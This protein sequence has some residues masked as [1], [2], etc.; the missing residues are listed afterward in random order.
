MARTPLLRR[1]SET[2]WRPA[3]A[4]SADG[5]ADGRVLARR[6]PQAC[7]R[8]RRR[9]SPLGSGRAA[10]R[11]QAATAPRIAIVG[12]GIAG[13]NAA[14]TLAGQGRTARRSTRR[15]RPNRRPHALR[16]VGLLGERAGVR[17]LRRAD[18]HGSQEDPQPREHA[19]TC[20]LVDLLAA[21]PSGTEDTYWF[22]GGDYPARPGR[23]R[24]SARSH[25]TL[26][27][28]GQGGRLSD[29]CTTAPRRRAAVR[30]DVGLR[31]DRGLRS[32]RPRL[33]IGRAARRRVQR[34]VRRRDEGPGVA[35]P[36][37]SARLPADADGFEVFG[38]SDERFHIAGGNQQ[39]P[40]AIAN[41]LG[42]QT[43]KLGLGDAGDPGQRRRHGVDERSR[44][45]ARSTVTADQVILCMSFAVL[46][47]ARHERRG[48][49]LA[50][51]DRDHAARRGSQ[52]EAA[53]AVRQPL[54]ERAGLDRQR[55]HRPR[56]P[57]R[58]GRDTRPGRRHRHPRRVRGREHRRR[59]QPL[60]AV[61]ER[62]DRIPR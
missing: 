37:L 62:G 47:D 41:H 34:G 45:P 25:K 44:R 50:E 59:L 4:S 40:E 48:L 49:R 31:L 61:L 21:Q 33:A 27:D 29:D 22:F 3:P 26:K 36:H 19:S 14:L 51:E 55:L 57:E 42:R 6:V 30:P 38:V 11:G 15:R 17:V 18:R 1:R 2:G 43:I 52:R 56:H 5:E 54:L 39:L 8:R 10:R 16:H 28:A 13:L 58:V 60:D 12:G 35:Q 20:R 7:G 24:T 53:A 32:R 46:R 23:S 9:A